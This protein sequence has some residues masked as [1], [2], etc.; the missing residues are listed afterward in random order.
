MKTAFSLA[1]TTPSIVAWVILEIFIF[2]THVI[3]QLADN[4]LRLLRRLPGG[5]AAATHVAAAASVHGGEE[6]KE[7]EVEI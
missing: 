7:V 6:E 3:S 1:L 5:P 4:E 2:C